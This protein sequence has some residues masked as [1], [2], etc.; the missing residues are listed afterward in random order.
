MTRQDGAGELV[1]TGPAL[2]SI[3]RQGAYLIASIHTALDDSQMVRFQQDLIEQIGRHRSRGVII[4]VA[5]LDVLDSFG[6]RTCATS[7]RWPGCAA[8]SRSSSASSPTW[9]SRWCSSAW[10]PDPSHTALDLEEGLAYL[11]SRVPRSATGG[12]NAQRSDMK[13]SLDTLTRDYR[14]AFLRYLPRREEAALHTGYE[15]GR[16]AVTA[17]LS[18]LEL[19]RVHHE[20]LVEVLSDTNSDDVARVASAASEFFLEVIATYDMAQRSFL[21]T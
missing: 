1:D 16:R 15:L 7:P 9:R 10:A 4:D 2:V 8:R 5:A 3:L 21:G 6:S 14:A 17:G 12:T 11:D 18:I 13:P 19:A 20:V